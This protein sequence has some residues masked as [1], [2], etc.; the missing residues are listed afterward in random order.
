MV[1]SMVFPFIMIS[2]SSGTE[3][4]R[5]VIPLRIGTASSSES[6]RCLVDTGSP[7]TF[8]DWRLGQLVGVNLI[9]AAKPHGPQKLSLD[10]VIADELGGAM[11]GFKIE[12]DRYRIHLGYVF[13]TFVRPWPI[14]EFKAILGTKG[15]KRIRVTV[16]A[17]VGDG[18]LTISPAGS[19]G[20]KQ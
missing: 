20:K 10:G 16:E 6:Q 18:Q 8:L 1:G 2:D 12:D 7:S 9:Q 3:M 19:R 17:G 5:P 13:A 15:M 14:P 11:L 4:F